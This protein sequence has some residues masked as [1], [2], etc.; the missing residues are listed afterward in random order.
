MC[1]DQSRQP[2]RCAL[3]GT[4]TGIGADSE[5]DS[6]GS[7]PASG[8]TP[9]TIT[10][11]GFQTRSDG[12]LGGTSG[13]GVSVTSSTTITATTAAHAAGAVNVVVTN[14]DSQSGTLLSGTA[15][16]IRRRQ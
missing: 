10:G 8:G 12:K 13:T 5:F 7:G 2:E 14:S 4:T 16:G 15:T 9:V 3:S 6:A 11:T 1:G